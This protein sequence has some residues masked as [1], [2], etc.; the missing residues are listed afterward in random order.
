MSRTRR[1]RAAFGGTTLVN[2]EPGDYTLICF[3]PSP[4]GTPHAALGMVAT[5]T[6]A[7]AA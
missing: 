3:F 2:L 1:R 7:P 6:V 4:D 5:F